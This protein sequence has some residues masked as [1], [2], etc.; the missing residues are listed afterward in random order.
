MQHTLH[1]QTYAY[2]ANMRYVCCVFVYLRNS[3]YINLHMH[4]MNIKVTLSKQEPCWQLHAQK[5]N[6][7]SSTEYFE[8]LICRRFSFL[9]RLTQEQ[10]MSIGLSLKFSGIYPNFEPQQ[11]SSSIGN[12]ME[13]LHKNSLKAMHQSPS[14]NKSMHTNNNTHIHAY[15][16]ET[17]SVSAVKEN[18]RNEWIRCC[19]LQQN[20]RTIN[21]CCWSECTTKQKR[22]SNNI[23]AIT[24]DRRFFVHISN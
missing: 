23:E 14:R 6:L 13:W 10:Q 4:L 18:R 11:V 20:H 3:A 12:T 21:C 19:M 1:V 9:H 5:R 7:A 8:L 2:D 15:S 22:T 24:H 17:A 16:S